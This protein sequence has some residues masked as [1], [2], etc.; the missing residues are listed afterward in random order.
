MTTEFS[1][2]TSKTSG[3]VVFAAVVTAIAALS[4]FV[5][6]LSLLL[7]DTWVV[8]T[9]DAL[10]VFNLTTAGVIFLL[11]AA[12]QLVIALALFSGDLWARVLGILGASLGIITHM[13]FMSI[14]PQWAWLIIGTDVLVIYALAV[15]GNDVGEW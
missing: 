7:N 2:T 11:F 14:Y 8:L 3:W 10:L 9:S 6:G 4:N 13:T 1:A 5:F 12:F 15:H